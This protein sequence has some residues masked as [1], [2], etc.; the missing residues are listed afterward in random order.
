VNYLE[1]I[2]N[3]LENGVSKQATRYDNNGNVI[4]VENGTIGTFCEIFRHDM[5]KGFPL[6]TLRKM[7]WR[8]IRVELEGFIKGITDKK[9]YE[10]RKCGF[11]SEWSNP[12]G[13]PKSFNVEQKKE[14]QLKDTDLGNVYGAQWRNFNLINKPI[15]RNLNNLKP[16]VASVGVILNETNDKIDQFLKETWESIL[17]KCYSISNK[18]Y[19]N[20]GGQGIYVVNRWLTYEYFKE[21]VQNILGWENKISNP[22]DFTLKINYIDDCCYG[23]NSCIWSNN[24]ENIFIN[25]NKCVDQLQSIVEKLKTS[26]YD[27]RMVCSAWNPNQINMMALPPCHWGWNV[28]VYGEKLNLIWH[29][30]SCDLLLGVGANIASY[31]LL[32][33]LL[34]KESGLKPGELVGTLA[35]CHIYENHMNAARKLIER[36]ENELPELIIE[37]KD[38]EFSIFNWTYD[39]ANILNYNP[40]EKLEIGAVT[41]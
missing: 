17:N 18:E 33:M 13:I 11:W 31:G 16:T 15:P 27:R 8:S 34:A 30:R 12:L 20:Y 3:V 7:P 4:H 35:D 22:I 40:H 2:K 9:W 26:P 32:L 21:D 6:T 28:V 41:V 39:Q 5:S 14:H 25:K 19:N 29:Q 38:D 36:T 37:N 10:D 1:I 23:P 24:K